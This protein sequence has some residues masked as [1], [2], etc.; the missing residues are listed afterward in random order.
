VQLVDAGVEVPSGEII[1]EFRVWSRLA[2]DPPAVLTDAL[3]R[4]DPDGEALLVTTPPTPLDRFAG[5]PIHGGR[6][7]D[8]VALEDKT[9]VDDLLDRAE[10]SRPRSAVVPVA[11]SPAVA[12]DLDIGDGTVWSGDAREGF[13]GGT[14]RVRW[15][16]TDDEAQAGAEFFEAEHDLVRVSPFVEGVPCSIHGIVGAEGMAVFRPCEMLVMR[17]AD[18]R[19]VYC[20]VATA[21]DPSESDRAAMRDSARRVGEVL[22]AEVAFRG[23]FTLDGI[24]S[25]DGFVATEVNPRFGGG[26]SRIASGVDDLPLIELHRELIAD[27]TYDPDAA[28]LEAVV[29]EA[30]DRQ[31]SFTSWSFLSTPITETT[32]F[33]FALDGGES[34]AVAPGAPAIEATVGPAVTGSMLRVDLAEVAPDPGPIFAPLAIEAL[35]AAG[36]LAGVDVPRMEAARPVR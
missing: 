17:T 22:R 11:G 20:G 29:V 24:M 26:M 16:V 3:D 7:P 9:R 23:T 34:V 32:T 15:I 4:F 6:R 5:R 2:A 10:V 30:A 1:E 36:D 33:R 13:N 18:H 27:P 14:T 21:W 12:H 35:R 31:R 8:W 28:A 25:A 19:F